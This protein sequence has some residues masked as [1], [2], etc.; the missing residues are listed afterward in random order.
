MI[1]VEAAMNGYFFAQSNV[2]GLLGGSLVA[3]VISL[4]NVGFSMIFGWFSRWIVHRSFLGKMAGLAM[5]AIWTAFAAGFNLSVGHFRDTADGRLWND[6]AIAAL[7]NL[8]AGPVDL[9]SIESWLLVGFGV[10]ISFFAFLKGFYLDDR[11]PGYGSVARRLQEAREDYAQVVEEAHDELLEKRDDAK[12]NLERAGAQARDEIN[13]A[14]D[15][16][17]ARQGLAGQRDVFLGHC[18]DVTNRLL[19]IYRES[20][21]RARSTPVPAHFARNHR[22]PM[23]EDG[24]ATEDKRDRARDAV[25]RIETSVE[26]AVQD[27]FAAFDKAIGSHATVDEVEGK[28]ASHSGVASSTGP[29]EVG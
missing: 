23:I 17:Y 9:Q 10:L 16:G 5:L 26:K 18:D 24:H 20:N 14:V 19:T 6:A 7:K 29:A 22:F 8:V 13:D 28:A 3:T 4:V 12:E 27:I 2:L 21:A 1:F 11:Y 25:R 15:V